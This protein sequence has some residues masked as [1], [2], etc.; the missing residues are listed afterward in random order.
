MSQDAS[1]IAA[2]SLACIVVPVAIA[3]LGQPISARGLAW[4][5]AGALVIAG[6][7][8]LHTTARA[9]RIVKMLAALGVTSWACAIALS[10]AW[11]VSNTPFLRTLELPSGNP[12]CR[13]RRIIA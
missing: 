7:S 13:V 9:H 3:A 12:S 11:P 2:A 1:R 6:L 5:V 10:L 8:L 4:L